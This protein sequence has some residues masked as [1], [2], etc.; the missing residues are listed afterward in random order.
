M[1]RITIREWLTP[2]KWI[3]GSPIVERIENY[4]WRLF[5]RFD[6]W[7]NG[8][9][10]YNM[11][12]D[13]RAKKNWKSG[14]LVLT[15]LF[16]LLGNDERGG[17]QCFLVANDL[18]QAGDDLGLAKKI[19]QANPIL[20]GEDVEIQA[21]TIIRVDG[22]GHLT[23]L[24]AGDAVGLHGKTY[25][26]CGYDEIHGQ[27]GWDLF[28]ALQPD[29][30]RLEVQQAMT[31]YASI[32][33]KPGVPLYDMFTRG[34]SGLDE[35]MLFSWYAADY[36]T[37]PDFAGLD[38]ESRANPSRASWDDQDYLKQQALRLPAHKFRR[39][40]LNLPGL[41]EGSAFTA[42]KIM[43]AIDRGV[44]LR[45]PQ[46]NVAYKAAVD[47]SG[48]SNDDAVLAIGHVDEDKRAV[49]DRVMGQGPQPPFDMMA[50]VARFAEEMK[51][52]RITKVS[53]DNYGGNTF[54]EAFRKLGIEPTVNE[55]SASKMY[56]AFEPLLNGGRVILLDETMVE[57]QFLGLVW[58][59][60]KIDH[61]TGEHD[62]WSNAVAS[63]TVQLLPNK[64]QSAYEMTSVTKNW[65]PRATAAMGYGTRSD[66]DKAIAW[67]QTKGQAGHDPRGI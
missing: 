15:A 23:I 59:G 52:Y 53:L 46:P 25:I 16:R 7:E 57:Q 42:E 9:P 44:L 4:R 58:R 11:K 66:L 1:N 20:L 8:R 36:C 50:A 62:D 45:Y 17:N 3:D 29:P 27:K 19:I 12:L 39:L 47:T 40:H 63:V 22:G 31:S 32:F 5:E 48:G 41:P 43:G 49:I 56:E 10:K 28:E 61:P 64:S 60:S 55:E 38:P 30:T 67:A 2:L 35:R 6:V 34:K 54:K 21:N 13:G 14:D 18:A 24:P 26:F 51:K 65:T 37:D 33:H